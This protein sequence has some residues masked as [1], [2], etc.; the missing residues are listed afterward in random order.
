MR[1]N[2]TVLGIVVL[3]LVLAGITL[4]AP[5]QKKPPGYDDTPMLPDGKWR[6]HDSK[7]PYPPI[8]HPGTFSSQDAPGKPPSD[9]VVLFDGDDLAKWKDSKGGDADWKIENGYVE[10]AAKTGPI[11]TKDEF[12]D[13]QLHIEWRAPDPP[14]GESQGRGN[15]G[16]F[17]MGLY[18]LQVLDSF[19]NP[20]YADGQAGSLYGQKPPLVNASRKPGEWQVYDVIFT[21]PHF[22]DGQLEKPAY[23]TVFHNGVVLHNHQELLGPTKHREVAHYAPHGPKGPIQLQDHGDPVRYRNIWVRPLKGYDEP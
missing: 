20:T 18:E 5:Q 17:L 22:K 21:A 2:R 15:S 23:M 12:G 9:A 4:A 11:T 1:Q 8:V 3:G 6:V 16:C 19:E 10:V 14:K 7:R 13:I